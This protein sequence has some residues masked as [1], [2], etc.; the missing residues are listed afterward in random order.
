MDEIIKEKIVRKK[1]EIIQEKPC[2]ING[3]FPDHELDKSLILVWKLLYK[4]PETRDSD[5]LLWLAYLQFHCSAKNEVTGWE[6]FKK[7]LMRKDVLQMA[8]IIRS[9]ALI[10]EKGYF[11][12][13]NKR[14]RYERAE[15]HRVYYGGM[16][17]DVD[18]TESSFE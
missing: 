7:F 13:K 5:K 3:E 1:V 17:E 14:E 15:T 2:P 12:G 11:W 10:Q 18:G 16:N 8:T 6:S 9:R 4:I